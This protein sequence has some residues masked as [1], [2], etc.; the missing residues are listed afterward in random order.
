M[1]AFRK[2]YAHRGAG[3]GAWAA[4]G[5][6]TEFGPPVGALGRDAPPGPGA[7]PWLL[8]ALT[9]AA[10]C[11]SPTLGLRSEGIISATHGVAYEN[12]EIVCQGHWKFPSG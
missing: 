11:A 9:T 10:L 3:A 5:A 8:L 12:M 2:T 1:G 6:R 7:A 4:K